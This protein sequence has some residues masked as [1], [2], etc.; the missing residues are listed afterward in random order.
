[1]E[2]GVVYEDVDVVAINKPSGLMVHADGKAAWPTVADWVARYHPEMV[3]VGEPA[4]IGGKEIARPGIVHRIDRETS[5]I[6]IL[7]KT[8]EA[9]AYLKREFQERRVVK[10]YHAFVYGTLPEERGTI[11]FPIGK[12]RKNFPLWSAEK[13]ARGNLRDAVTE[14]QVL[15]A[16]PEVSYVEV[17][18]KTGRTHQIRV[19]FKALRHPIVCD[20]LYAPG[21]PCLLGFERLALHALSLE[22]TLRS[23]TRMKFETPLPP[24]FERARE[25]LAKG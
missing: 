5:G 23:G 22:L 12:S 13:D 25:I 17:W 6:L 18:P 1:M 24:D 11:A 10:I 20:T 15:E 14:Y 2:V 8:S 3:D 9:Y 19:H 21:R 16:S 7:A 4:R